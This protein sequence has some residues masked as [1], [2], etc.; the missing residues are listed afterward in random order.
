MVCGALQLEVNLHLWGRVLS[1]LCS[2]IPSVRPEDQAGVL[3][4]FVH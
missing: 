3:I 4:S 1:V 2:E